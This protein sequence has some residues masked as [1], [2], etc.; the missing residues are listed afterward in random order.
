MRSIIAVCVAALALAAGCAKDDEYPAGG[1][2]ATPPSQ[3]GETAPPAPT[4][5][6]ESP[7]TTPPPTDQP[8]ATTPPSETP[9]PPNR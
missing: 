2:T 1:D 9:P 3:P 5:P 6:S 4:T 7:T 8:G